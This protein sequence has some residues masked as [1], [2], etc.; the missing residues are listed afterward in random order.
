M[1]LLSLYNECSKEVPQ[2][3]PQLVESRY[4]KSAV[5][6]TSQGSGDTAAGLRIRKA[7]DVDVL[8]LDVGC[9]AAP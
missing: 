4:S 1:P 6:A 5:S 9:L 8:M 2:G 7:N 3:T